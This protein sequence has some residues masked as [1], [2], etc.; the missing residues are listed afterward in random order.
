MTDLSIDLLHVQ[1]PMTEPFRISS[2]WVDKKDAILVRLESEG[3]VGWGEA[4]PMAGAFYSAETP[5]STFE[6]LRDK[7]LPLLLEDGRLDPAWVVETMKKHPE[8]RF[9]W[10]GLEGAL[11][12][13]KTQSEGTSLG[14]AI[15]NPAQ[16]VPSG[17]AVGI[18]DTPELLV[19]AVG[20]YLEQGG[21]LRVKVKIQ[22]GWDRVPLLAIRDAFP[23]VPLM[24]DA[25]AAYRLPDHLE[26]LRS[27]DEFGL[28]MIEQP[29]ASGA[30]EDH[31]R[32]AEKMATPIC[33]DESA[34]DRET[35]ARAID[36]GACRIVN[37]KVQRLGGMIATREVYDLC[38]TRGIPTW[39]GTMPELGLGSM[40][41]LYLATLPHH[42]YPT[43]VESS[44]RWF[45]EEIL[46]PPIEAKEGLIRIPEAHRERP[47]ID[48]AAIEKRLL[49]R[50]RADSAR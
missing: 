46:D 20:G 36:L 42:G 44:A 21:Y 1:I 48:A 19:K 14:K 12:D 24:V 2:G 9:A 49:R 22:P 38:A 32:L 41:A 28:I 15:G 31:A 7:A 27:L 40:H 35:V 4:S 26:V 47:Q 17:L 8:E 33:L 13:W 34:K 29:L 3:L 23:E 11:W 39:M 37:L 45:L 25:N 6:F 5:E 43:D 16:P 18:Y 30:L 50:W 10:T